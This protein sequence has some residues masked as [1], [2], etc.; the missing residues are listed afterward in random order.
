[1]RDGALTCIVIVA[2]VAISASPARAQESTL[3]IYQQLARECM[4]EL[5]SGIDSLQLEPTAQMPYLRSALIESWQSGGVEV[6]SVDS[7][8]PQAAHLPRLSFTVEDAVVQYVRADRR[9]I[10]RQVR[11]GLQYSLTGPDGR[12]I[13]DERCSRAAADI[14]D[15]TA[16][17]N[18]ENRAYS[19]TQ[20]ELPRA[21]WLRRIVE[22]AVITAAAA[23][24]VYLFFTLRSQSAEDG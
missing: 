3:S 24:G 4:G 23:I 7:S 22:P 17:A 8:P 19:E 14:I 21:G 10:N 18:I 9:R 12:I 5:P 1:M 16:V 2:L 20:G 11:L 15:R 6:Y 13:L